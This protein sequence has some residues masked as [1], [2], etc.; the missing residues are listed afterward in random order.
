MYPS[1]GDFSRPDSS[2]QASSSQNNG[3]YSAPGAARWPPP[4]LSNVSTQNGPP[5]LQTATSLSQTYPL[6]RV[7]IAD[8]YRTFPPVSFT[9][10][11][12][13]AGSDSRTEHLRHQK[14]P[15]QVMIN[16][17]LE[18]IPKSTFQYDFTFER[19]LITK[20][21]SPGHVSNSAVRALTR[22]AVLL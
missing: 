9:P 2:S 20:L 15:S 11:P 1:I 17:G 7:H 3:P 13:F 21:Q 6:L 22:C 8:Q 10:L 18:E 4:Q 16:P 14:G 5:T 12:L 19:N